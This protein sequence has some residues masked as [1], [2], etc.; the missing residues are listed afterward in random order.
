MSFRG[1]PERTSWFFPVAARYWVKNLRRRDSVGLR[2]HSIGHSKR[3]QNIDSK[4]TI[5][6]KNAIER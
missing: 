6:H 5:F 3:Q 4:L 2:A 1:I